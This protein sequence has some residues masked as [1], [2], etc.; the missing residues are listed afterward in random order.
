MGLGEGGITAPGA[1][2][3][4]TVRGIEGGVTGTGVEGDTC[5]VFVATVVF[6][7]ATVPVVEVAGE[8]GAIDC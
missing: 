4:D 2:G 7:V 1:T 5:A 3:G 6:W 8:T